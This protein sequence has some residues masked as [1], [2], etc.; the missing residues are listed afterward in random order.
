MYSIIVPT[1]GI[2][3]ISMLDNL[4]CSISK[5]YNR[6]LDEIIVSDDSSNIDTIS[7]LCSLRDRYENTFNI[8]PVF[9]PSYHSFAKTVNSGMKIS[10]P[11]NDIL[12]LNNDMLALTNFESF[13]EFMKGNN[14][15]GIIGSKLIYPNGTIQHAGMVRMRLIKYFRHIYKYR[16]HNHPPTNF[17]K[18]YIS[19]TG[20]CL[21]INRE[22]IN[23]IGYLDDRYILSY[24]DVDYCINSQANGYDVWYIPDVVMTH[25]ESATR[26][27]PYSEHNRALLWRKWGSS[28]ETI[29]KKQNIPDDDLDVKVVGAS[30]ITG[31]IYLISKG[32][33]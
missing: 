29:R 23:R 11:N 2:K 8:I 6:S 21:Y 5:F 30:G 10:N 18:K 1:Y 12:L 28:Y 14:K 16:S 17:P 25:Y 26:T 15:I 13:V 33:I 31:I 24:E 22:L 3:G 32:Y 27:D 20:A 4:L 7:A 19:V 9:N